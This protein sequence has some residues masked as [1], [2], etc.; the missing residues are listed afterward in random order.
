MNSKFFAT[1]QHPGS[2]YRG[3]P[4]WS[5]NGKL[6]P[7][8]LQRQVRILHHMGMGGF[9]MHA[10]V[11]LVTPYLSDE[12]FQAVAAS[13]TEAA[14]C[15]MEAW[16]YDED[17]WP[18]GAAGGLVTKNPKYR[19]QRVAIHL[20]TNPTDVPTSGLRLA[21]FLGHVNGAVVSHLRRVNPRRLPHPSPGET[22]IVF[23]L[24][25]EPTSDWFNGYTYL[26]TMNKE[27][28]AAFI[29]CTHEAYV[30]RFPKECG[31]RIPGIFTDEPHHGSVLSPLLGPDHTLTMPW[32]RNLPAIFQRRYGYD[33]VSHLPEVV[34]DVEGIRSRRVRYDYHNCITSLFVEAFARQIG[35]WCDRHRLLHTGHILCEETLSSQTNVV[36]STMRFYEYMQAPGMDLLTEHSREYDTAKQ[37]ASVAH[38]FGRRWR[39][40]ETY[41][42]TGWD[43][44][45]EGHKALGD[46]QVALGI[47]LRAHH[48][49]WYTMLGQAKRD[50]PASTF[51]QSPWWPFYRYV[52]DYFA[53]IHTVM[54]RGEE[55]RDLLVIHPVESMWLL[56]KRN[57]HESKEV[58]LYDRVL[59]DLRDT[60]LCAQLDFDYG[61]EDILAR[62]AT[63]EKRQGTPYVRVGKARY[64]VV[65][66]PPLLTMRSSTLALLQ[67]FKDAG[68]LIVFAGPPA[69]MLDAEPAQNVKKFAAL[70]VRTPAKGPK[71]VAA[72][73]HLARRISI[74]NGNAKPLP[75]V[76]Y[77]L[78]EDAEAAYL[79]ICNTSLTRRQMQGASPLVRD[80]RLAFPHVVI[81]GLPH[82]AGQP[83]EL[84]PATGAVYHA[85][86]TR[87]QNGW[88]VETSLPR[89]ASRL[90][91]FPKQPTPTHFPS[92]PTTHE[93][94]SIPLGQTRWPITLSE[95]NVLVLDRPAFRIGDADWQPPQEILRVDMAVRDA[96][97][98][99]HRGGAM[100]QPWAQSPSPSHPAIPVALRYSF[101]VE[102]IPHGEMY[103]ALESPGNFSATL[104]GT[105]L[106]MDTE[107]GWW[108][109]PSLRKIPVDPSV[110][111][112][113]TN[114]LL[115]LCRYDAQYAGLEIVYLLGQFGTTVRSEHVIITPLPTSLRIGDWVPQGLTFYSGNV[116]YHTTL[117]PTHAHDEHVFV[118]VPRYQG[119]AVRVLVNG[120]QA[121]IIA[122]EP[123]EVEITSYLQSGAVTL[124]LE[125]LGHRRNSHGPLHHTQKWPS[126]TGPHEFVTSGDQWTDAYQLVPCG[127]L[128]RPR[129]VIRR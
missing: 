111:R 39:L 52:E 24:E 75:P 98:L 123:N 16:L 6:D 2:A 121:G 31:T 20:V 124:S 71:I 60:L 40:T 122:W 45:F 78:R 114:E 5:W 54:T 13:V 103:L 104:N 126:W 23:R 46:W 37:V 3:K 56:V 127:I 81:R 18:S 91:V 92:R 94:R 86:A 41:G 100:K 53:R 79:F 72:V 10:R 21:A 115:L 107:C 96:L 70:C 57:W 30:R 33:L 85:S 125:V 47:N 90:F 34:F 49:C 36:G 99:P 61:D 118:Q 14:R 109:D 113:G 89:L 65:I 55:V 117:T 110:L 19:M 15:D 8:E 69:P 62:H 73:E 29:R 112:L 129:L 106:N 80:R 128:A 84:D 42:C 35:E 116:A 97:H 12:W 88:Q 63:V 87:T 59:Q 67:R 50:Y 108:V 58:L 93:V 105:P 43:F 11:G 7:L 77:L 32:T 1:F 25:T 48:L 26:D 102:S 27:A 9:F 4:F 101:E 76:L 120:Q 51:F 66:V 17:R 28:V 68:G 83:L 22:L 44:S 119:T 95:P 38:Q 82:C 64:K 74:T